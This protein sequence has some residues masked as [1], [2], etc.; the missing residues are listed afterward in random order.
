MNKK[1]KTIVGQILFQSKDKRMRLLNNDQIKWL[2]K[3][4]RETTRLAKML[5]YIECTDKNNID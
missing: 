1:Q 5:P 3:K 2:E 4:M